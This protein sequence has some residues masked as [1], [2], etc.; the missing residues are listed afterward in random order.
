MNPIG[1]TL[2]VLVLALLVMALGLG[3][4]LNARLKALRAGQADFAKSVAELDTAS[5]RA[6]ASLA[7]MRR[8]AEVTHDALQDRIEAARGLLAKLE[9]AG[10]ASAARAPSAS[11]L[12]AETPP[13]LRGR[14]GEETLPLSRVSGG[15]VDRGTRATEGART[16]FAS[17]DTDL[18]P[19]GFADL[20]RRTLREPR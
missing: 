17:S 10:E 20:I 4:K 15:A 19:A 6:E 12:R 9:A 18:A 14:G 3:L 11:T 2:D 5:R 13:P 7:D 1:A 16:R 8:G